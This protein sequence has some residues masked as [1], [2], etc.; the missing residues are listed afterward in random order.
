MTKNKKTIRE[1]ARNIPVYKS[2]DVLVVGGG[3]AGSSAAASAERAG[4]ETILVE[5]YGYLGGLSTGGLVIWIDRMSDW[6]G[7]KVI[8]G[9]ADDLLDRLPGESILGPP[10]AVW[11]SKDPEIVNYWKSRSCAF[12]DTVTWS[13]TIDPEVLKNTSQCF[14]PSFLSG[15]P[16]NRKLDCSRTKPILRC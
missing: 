12:Q 15:S 1:Q 13:P 8:T 4:A 14:R 6:K 11:G 3:P 2:C 7:T 5:R 9:F 10:K 16:K